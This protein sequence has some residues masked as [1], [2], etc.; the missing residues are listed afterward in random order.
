MDD[1]TLL[2]TV[3]RALRVDDA[4]AGHVIDIY[5]KNRPKASNLD[6][7]MILTSDAGTLRTAG[8][9]IAEHKAALNKAPVYLYEFQWNSPV[10]QGK[11]RAMHG[12]E[13]GFVFDHVDDVQWMIGNGADRYALAE[14]ISRAWVAFARTGNP[15]HK[16][17]PAWRPFNAQARPTMVFDNECGCVDDPHSE[18]RLAIASL[19]ANQTRG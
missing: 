17:L 1:A 8:Y 6:I 13:L 15:N 9:T 10:R 16:G 18:E 2:T 14:K 11:V 19:Q 3:K 5:R 7:A 4:A 12:V